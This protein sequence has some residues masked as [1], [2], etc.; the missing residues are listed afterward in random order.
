MAGQRC[1]DENGEPVPMDVEQRLG[2]PFRPV[3]QVSVALAHDTQV[4]QGGEHGVQR[5]ALG[6]GIEIDVQTRVHCGGP[7]PRHQLV[8]HT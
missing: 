4:D 1:R 8:D 2:A 3:V 7:N 6:D 5:A